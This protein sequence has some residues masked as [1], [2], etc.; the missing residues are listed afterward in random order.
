MRPEVGPL[1]ALAFDAIAAR[2]LT[3]P[4]SLQVIFERISIGFSGSLL[5]A[6]GGE[7][8]DRTS[9]SKFARK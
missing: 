9:T 2:W 5:S 8:A 1:T 7:V 3:S 4:T 6:L